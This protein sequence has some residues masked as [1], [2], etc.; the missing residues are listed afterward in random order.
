MRP[1]IAT[2]LGA[3]PKA[4]KK[5]LAY[6]SDDEV[7]PKRKYVRKATAAQAQP[8]V[9]GFMGMMVSPTEPDVAERRIKAAS[10]VLELGG[11]SQWG[12]PL[13]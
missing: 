6:D 9:G 13:G 11:G 7:K 2:E 10:Q 8:V 1:P 5:S 4:K 3:K 12:H